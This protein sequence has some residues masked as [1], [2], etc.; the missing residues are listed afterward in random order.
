MHLQFFRWDWFTLMK[1]S[2]NPRIKD[3][4]EIEL[5]LLG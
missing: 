1:D 4:R 2:S 5:L 3:I